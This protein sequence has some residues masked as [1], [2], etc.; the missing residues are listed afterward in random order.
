MLFPLLELMPPRGGAIFYP[1]DMIRRLY[2]KLLRRGFVH[3]F[4]IIRVWQIM[5]PRGGACLDPRGIVGR[6]YKK[7]HYIHCYTQNILEEFENTSLYI[8]YY[9]V[10]KA[11]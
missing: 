2:V 6:I 3:V 4:P 8:G 1:R 5:T 7:E 11:V 9:F 10:Y